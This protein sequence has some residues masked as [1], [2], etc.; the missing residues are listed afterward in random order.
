M[1]VNELPSLSNTTR[2][3][4]TPTASDAVLV[5]STITDDGSIASA[6]LTYTATTGTLVTTSPFTETFGTTATPAGSVWTGT[7]DNTWNVVGA[8]NPFKLMTSVNYTSS[9]TACG[10]Q[11]NC[12]KVTS[13][14]ITTSSSINAAATSGYVELYVSTTSLGA[15]ESWA[16]QLDPTGTG[17]SFVT[18]LSET[19]T[20]AGITH[21]MTKYHYD[22]T[23]TELVATLKIR[24]VFTGTAIAADAGRINLDQI[25]LTVSTGSSNTATLTMFDDGTHGDGAAGD[26]VY[27]AQIPAQT[28]GTTVNYYLTATDNAGLAA[29]NPESA[30][31]STYSYVVQASVDTVGDGIP[32]WWRA[33]YFGGDG[34]TTTSISVATADPDGDGVDN[35]HEYLA[36]S[37]PVNALSYFRIMSVS[38]TTGFTVIF[39]SSANRKYTLY[40]T[41]NLTSGEW[42]EV[43][44][45]SAITGNGGVDTLT[46]PAPTGSP[47][48]YRVGVQL[49]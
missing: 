2:T 42:T 36:D 25:S 43:A 33:K 29:T 11:F 9:S 35:Y 6:E 1:V 49:P 3:P 30:P 32:D 45:Q 10:M 14:S 13:A 26:H 12:S 38:R 21:A 37:Q 18:R 34:K 17:N 5:T 4:S 20:T 44:S 7:G 16:M 41:I 47:R 15:A 27:G 48:F 22:L 8:P 39:Q 31:T 28:P 46:D 40:S 19:G 24:L 23:N